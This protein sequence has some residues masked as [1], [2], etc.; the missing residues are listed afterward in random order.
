MKHIWLIML[1]LLGVIAAISWADDE[2]ENGEDKVTNGYRSGVLG[3]VHDFSTELADVGGACRACHVPH[4]QAF[5]PTTQPAERT[6]KPPTTQPTIGM[7]PPAF[8]MYRIGGQ[9][10]VFVPGRYAPGPTSLLCLGCHDGTVATSTLSAAHSMLAGVRQGFQMPDGF[11]WRDHPIGIAYP[12]DPHEFHPL[13]YVQQRGI[14]L[15]EGRL[16]CVSCHDPH[17]E[18]GR[19]DLLSI[20][21]RQSRLCLTCHQK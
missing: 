3:G 13:S 11:V 17:N 2:Q 15:P 10:E 16:E 7:S 5:R 9:R 4:V 18:A 14:R 20:T 19:D 21:N 8:E 12:S 6:S 1:L